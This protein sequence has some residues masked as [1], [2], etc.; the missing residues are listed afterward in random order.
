MMYKEG[1]MVINPKTGGIA[2]IIKIEEDNFGWDEFNVSTLIYTLEGR[3][4]GHLIRIDEGKLNEF[5]ETGRLQWFESELEPKK[6]NLQ[7]KFVND[8]YF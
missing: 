7:F 8:N 5:L 3:R 1:Q 2:T 4:H 6:Y